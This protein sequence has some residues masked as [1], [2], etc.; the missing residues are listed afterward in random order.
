MIEHEAVMEFLGMF[1]KQF[2]EESGTANYKHA[3]TLQQFLKPLN[4][5]TTNSDA[6][7]KSRE[8]RQ[9]Y[10]GEKQSNTKKRKK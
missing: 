5:Y 3:P 8:Q 7:T 9:H 1:S 4:L 6:V 2:H 10:Q